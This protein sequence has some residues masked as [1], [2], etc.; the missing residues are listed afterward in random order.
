MKFERVL[1][2]E[3]S[4]EFLEDYFADTILQPE[5]K[6]ALIVTKTDYTNFQLRKFEFKENLN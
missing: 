6:Y 2:A 3:A 1:F 5:Q 4:V